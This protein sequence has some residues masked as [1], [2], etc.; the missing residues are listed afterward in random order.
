MNQPTILHLLAN[1]CN[2]HLTLNSLHQI[3]SPTDETIT[4][5]LIT[6]TKSL[7][8]LEKIPDYQNHLQAFLDNLLETL[9]QDYLTYIHDHEITFTTQDPG[10]GLTLCTSNCTGYH[11]SIQALD[12]GYFITE[13]VALT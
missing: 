7:D 8:E 3:T 9:K 11:I 12:C 10:V 1:H 5:A 4:T 13:V 2:A 6:F